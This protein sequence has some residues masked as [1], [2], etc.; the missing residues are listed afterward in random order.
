MVVLQLPIPSAAS[1]LSWDLR[2]GLWWWLT[3]KDWVF[4]NLS[5]S[6][7]GP[8]V[9]LLLV[10]ISC[11]DGWGTYCRIPTI[12]V[13]SALRGLQAAL[14]SRTESLY[15]SYGRVGGTKKG[16]GCSD[17]PHLFSAW[18]SPVII[19]VGNRYRGHNCLKQHGQDP[20]PGHIKG[21]EASKRKSVPMTIISD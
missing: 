21:L 7:H 16:R 11:N 14:S 17:L 20:H 18:H 15:N 13:S 9:G 12:R 19:V 1:S 10:P 8:V 5:V 2:G 6:A 4:Q 3:L